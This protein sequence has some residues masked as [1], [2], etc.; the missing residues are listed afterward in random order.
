M[1][2]DIQKIKHTSSSSAAP[3]E[4][5]FLFP[6]KSSCHQ[7]DVSFSCL[8]ITLRAC[9]HIY[10]LQLKINQEAC[11]LGILM[12][13]LYQDTYLC[14]SSALLSEHTENYVTIFY[15]FDMPLETCSVC[16]N[17]S[18]ITYVCRCLF[19]WKKCI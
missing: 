10:P 7:T 15:T 14:T 1:A 5:F 16:K 2:C 13:A 3:A 19:F 8:T 12:F 18:L 6:I 9:V 17:L 11:P 4:F